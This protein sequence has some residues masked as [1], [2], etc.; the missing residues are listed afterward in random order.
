MCQPVEASY[1][2]VNIWLD[3]LPYIVH[4][5]WLDGVDLALVRIQLKPRGPNIQKVPN[6]KTDQ[7][8]HGRWAESRIISPFLSH[9]S[10]KLRL[11]G[12]VGYFA[13]NFQHFLSLIFSD[14]PVRVELH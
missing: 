6:P 11:W 14:G 7:L 12:H 4:Q 3:I 13:W 10:P 8:K 2:K 1:Q 5:S 9:L